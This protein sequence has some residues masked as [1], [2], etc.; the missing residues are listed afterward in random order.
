VQLAYVKV[1]DSHWRTTMDFEMKIRRLI[2]IAAK[3]QSRVARNAT[4]S[5]PNLLMNSS[6]SET[7]A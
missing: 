5:R 4:K 6:L 1:S 3:R 2:N 7:F